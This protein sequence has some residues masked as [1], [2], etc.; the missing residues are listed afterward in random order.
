MHVVQR[1]VVVVGV[2]KSHAPEAVFGG[3][4]CKHLVADIQSTLHPAVSGCNSLRKHQD[5]L[6]KLRSRS[7]EICAQ[8][9]EQGKW[10]ESS[11]IQTHLRGETLGPT[12]V[13]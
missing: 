6:L 3:K 10:A 11:D 1:R 8:L 2:Q 7:P 5:L 9:Y 13:V 4:C 12:M